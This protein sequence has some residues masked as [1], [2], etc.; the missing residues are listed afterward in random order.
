MRYGALAVALLC[1]SAWISP[2]PAQS[3]Q[4]TLVSA[5]TNNPQLQ[6]DRARQRA[7]DEDVSRAW[8]GLRPTATFSGDKG[9]TLEKIKY[10]NTPSTYVPPADFRS[11]NSENLQLRQEIWD[12][13]R[14]LSDVR[15]SKLAVQ[16]GLAILQSTE[17]SVLGNAVQAYYDLYRDQRILTIQEGYV[18]AL[19]EERKATQARYQVKD[20]TQTDI[21]QADA[22]LAS[23]IA[24]AQ[25][26]QANVESSKSAFQRAAGMV[27]A[28]LLPEPPPVPQ[29]LPSSLDDALAAARQNP[30]LQAAILNEKA[31]RA[32]IATA[33]AG[34]LPDISLQATSSRN[35]HTDT[36]LDTDFNNTVVLALTV[37]LYD[38][39]L[40]SARVRTAKHTAGQ[41]RLDIDVMRDQV[42]DQVKRAWQSLIASRARIKSYNETVKANEVALAG[43]QQELRV[44]SRTVIDELNAR[45][46]LLVAQI[47]L[48]RARHDEAVAAYTVLVGCGRLTA[49]DLGVPV[50]IY[51]PTEH[52]E[53]SSWLPWGPW[54]DTDYPE[55]PEA[56]DHR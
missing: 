19:E 36:N 42:N 14:T 52:Y 17:Q 41:R 47:S 8:S 11:P 51:D 44:G 48:L 31:A 38:G 39:G 32:D 49:K 5:Y 20:V 54:I 16:N 43:V 46:E 15:H 23:G 56:S 55:S 13:G 26:Y 1:L 4:D 29:V 3:L 9:R 12:G 24:D 35:Y 18:R 53:S 25:Q 22:R 34:M 2:A 7:T 10:P 28:D 50:D 21:A 27:P 6:S 33:E 45:Q 37:P 40:A 30:D